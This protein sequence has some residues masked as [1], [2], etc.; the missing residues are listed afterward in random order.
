MKIKRANHYTIGQWE[1]VYLR[2]TLP[3]SST[4]TEIL[5]AKYKETTSETVHGVKMKETQARFFITKIL[6]GTSKWEDFDF[7]TMCEGAPILWGKREGK[8]VNVAN[9]NGNWS[10]PSNSPRCKKEKESTGNL[11]EK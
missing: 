6:A 4:P 8:E 3:A 2:L 11:A 10:F 1:E 5:K 7:D 9:R